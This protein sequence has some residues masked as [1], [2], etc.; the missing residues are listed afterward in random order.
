MWSTWDGILPYLLPFLDPVL[1]LLILSVGP[2]VFK[3]I[4]AFMKG[5][6]DAMKAQTLEIYYHLLAVSDLGDD[7][8]DILTNGP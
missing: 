7:F 8:D 1:G 2:F 6:I 5:Q 3:R 4:M